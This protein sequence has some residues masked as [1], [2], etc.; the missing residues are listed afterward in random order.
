MP[1]ELP[2][3]P[4]GYRSLTDPEVTRLRQQYPDLWADPNKTCLTCN[5]TG[6]FKTREVATGDIVEVACDCIAQWK[7]H[8]WMLNAGIGLR[9][10]RITWDEAQMLSVDMLTRRGPTDAEALGVRPRRMPEVL[11]V[12]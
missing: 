10:Q 3:L 9:Y 2:P 8:R 11:G 1:L 5:K 12:R 6:S 4:K 7:M